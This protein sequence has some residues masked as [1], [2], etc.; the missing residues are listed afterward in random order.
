MPPTGSESKTARA[1]GP[2]LSH[3]KLWPF[4]ETDGI[5]WVR[6]ANTESASSKVPASR[7][8][9]TTARPVAIPAATNA[10]NPNGPVR[11][12]AI[13]STNGRKTHACGFVRAA[14]AVNVP[15]TAPPNGATACTRIRHCPAFRTGHHGGTAKVAPTAARSKAVWIESPCP[16]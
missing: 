9:R 6:A 4:A 16:Q 14:K 10:P 15:A 5:T 1:P 3:H 8:G 7:H 12:H 2:S 11:F 13:H